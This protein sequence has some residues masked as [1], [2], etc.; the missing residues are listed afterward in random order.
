MY[1][2]P[3]AQ[4]NEEAR[5]AADAMAERRR[6]SR[7]KR[8]FVTQATPWAPGI[9]SVPFEVIIEDISERGVG[10]IH[11]EPMSIGVPHL[12]NVPRGEEGR[13]MIHQYVVVRCD[14]RGDGKYSIGLELSRDRCEMPI[15]PKRV[16]SKRLK[17]LFL[18][19]GIFGLIIASL[20]PL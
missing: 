1:V 18:L 5:I 12:L 6:A 10:L 4:P 3:I 11:D 17:I 16:C 13:S 15:E 2:N 14:H 7:M 9:P 19:F 8:K 20:A